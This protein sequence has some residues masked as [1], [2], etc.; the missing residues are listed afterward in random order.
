MRS[1][2]MLR[3]SSMPRLSSANRVRSTEK[4]IVYPASG[5]MPLDATN[6][7]KWKKETAPKKREKKEY[8]STRLSSDSLSGQSREKVNYQ[9]PQ[10]MKY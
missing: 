6:E 8:Q 10:L 3:S 2:A 7:L 9:V 5:S 1:L 4:N